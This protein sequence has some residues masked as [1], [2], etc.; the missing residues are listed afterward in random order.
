MNKKLKAQIFLRFGSQRAFAFKMQEDESYVS[1]VVG[2]WRTPDSDK[3][4]M[5]AAALRCDV[6]DIFPPELDRRVYS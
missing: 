6:D 1:K 3:Q 2:G 5:W 4:K